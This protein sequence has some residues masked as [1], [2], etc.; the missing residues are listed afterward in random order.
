MKHSFQ[1]CVSGLTYTELGELPF[2]V[3]RITLFCRCDDVDIFRSF[4]LHVVSRCRKR[5]T[6][7]YITTKDLSVRQLIYGFALVWV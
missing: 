1:S 5:L 2:P 4:T 6:G 7:A 3:L